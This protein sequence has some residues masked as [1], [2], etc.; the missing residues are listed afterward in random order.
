M[1]KKSQTSEKSNKKWKKKVTESDR[2]VKK[3][4]QKVKRSKKK[5]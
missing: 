4:L 3:K 1:T 2:L 5:W